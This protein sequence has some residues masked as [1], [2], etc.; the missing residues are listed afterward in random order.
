MDYAKDNNIILKVNGKDKYEAN[1][2][3]Y[4]T[5]IN[6]TVIAKLLIN[7]DEYHNIILA[8]I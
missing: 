5:K 3:L 7:Y 2:F 1:S 8:I 4:T 6:C